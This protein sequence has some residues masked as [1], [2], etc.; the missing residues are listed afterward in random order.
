MN[1]NPFPLTLA[2]FFFFLVILGLILEFELRAKQVLLLEPHSALFALVICQVQS[3][4]FAWGRL[5]TSIFL[6]FL[7]GWDYRIHHHTW[8]FFVEMGVN[9]LDAMELCI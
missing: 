5:W 9:V 3:H 7:C 1:Y 2:L 8:L 6:C 4:V